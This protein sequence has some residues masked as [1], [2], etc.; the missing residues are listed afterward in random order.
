LLACAA[1]GEQPLGQRE[2]LKTVSGVPYRFAGEGIENR[3]AAAAALPI[4]LIGG[5]KVAVLD[6]SDGIRFA[7]NSLKRTAGVE[8]SVAL[9]VDAGQIHGSGAERLGDLS[10]RQVDEDNASVF[11]E[12]YRHL[13]AV[14]DSDIFGFRILRGIK[15]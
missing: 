14:I 12:G 3:E 7:G 2:V 15:S 6:P 1:F 9:R 8:F 13:V 4:P 11:L 5:R 10:G